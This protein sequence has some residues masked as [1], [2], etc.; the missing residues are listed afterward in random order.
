MSS[1][2]L[3]SIII[4]TYNCSEV[5]HLTLESVLLQDLSDFE[6]WVVGRRVHRQ[7]CGCRSLAGPPQ[8]SLGESVP[9]TRAD[10]PYPEMRASAVRV[11]DGFLTSVTTISGCR[12][13]YP[14]PFPRQKNCRRSSL[15]RLEFS[16]AQ[17]ACLAASACP[18]RAH[19][20]NQYHLQ[21]GFIVKI[22]L[23]ESALGAMTLRYAD[24][25]E[26]LDRIYRF[27]VKYARC[28]SLSVLKYPAG[29]WKIY[30]RKID[31]P[32]ARELESMRR[33]ARAL[34]Q[35]LLFDLAMLLSRRDMPRRPAGL[36]RT[37]L[38]LAMDFYGNDRWPLSLVNYRHYRTLAGLPRH[39]QS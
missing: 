29:S 18:I 11:V 13:T 32:Q 7:H 28:R 26:S 30:D 31:L 10:P 39:R 19:R 16:L 23:I 14:A 3:V 35:D 4:P 2:P 27:G 20:T 12:G 21:V 36:V 24:D 34:Q 9:A 6:V 25:R 22:S 1:L 8:D 5:L 38:R 15:H 37:L 33:D 17:P